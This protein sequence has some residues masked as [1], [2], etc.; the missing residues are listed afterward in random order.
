MRLGL[1]ESAASYL[2][3]NAALFGFLLL[4]WLGLRDLGF[5]LAL[6]ATGLLVAGFT[7][8]GVRWTGTITG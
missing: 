6:R 2:V 4:L 7:Q 5:S 8:G 3:T 1:S